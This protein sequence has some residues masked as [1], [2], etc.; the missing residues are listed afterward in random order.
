M[1]HISHKKD[2]KKIGRILLKEETSPEVTDDEGP[3]QR[4][5]LPF[6]WESSLLQNI[7]RDLDSMKIQSKRRQAKIARS[8]IM[9]VTA[10]TPP[11]SSPEWAVSS[12]YTVV[13]IK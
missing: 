10:T 13:V 3:K 4:K 2:K 6:V 7:K 5:V 8:A 11:K 9:E 1:M 12:K